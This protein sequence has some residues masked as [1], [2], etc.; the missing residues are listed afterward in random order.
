MKLDAFRAHGVEFIDPDAP[1]LNADCPFCGKRRKF[2]VN[3]GNL[4]WDCKVCGR[5]GNVQGFLEQIHERDQRAITPAQIAEIV[6]DRRLPQSALQSWHPGYGPMSFIDRKTGEVYKTEDCWQFA[7]RDRDG[8]LVDLR[9]YRPEWGRFMSTKSCNTGLFGAQDLENCPGA[10]VWL[11]EGEWDAIALRWLLRRC[12]DDGI[13]VSVPGAST[14]KADWCPW[15]GGR[16]VRTL[17]DN[18][19]AGDTGEL[20]AQKRLEG[21]AKKV[22]YVRWP[23]KAPKGFDVR[24]FIVKMALEREQPRKCLATLKQMFYDGPRQ[25]GGP[26]Q[27]SAART[28][29]V[30]REVRREAISLE[31]LHEVYRKWLFLDNT[32]GV[33]VTMAVMVSNRIEGDPLWMFIVGPPS[34]AKT[35]LLMPLRG[36]HDAHFTDSLTAHTLCSGF[37]PKSGDPSL[38]PR[39]NGKVLVVKDFTTILSMRDVVQD[40][41][42]GDLRAAYDGHFRKP[43]GNGIIREYESRFSLIGAVTPMIYNRAKQHQALGERF[44]KFAICENLDHAHEDDIIAKSISNMNQETRMRDELRDAVVS[45]LGNEHLNDVAELPK[46][47]TRRIVS[48]ARFGARM[49]GTVMRDPYRPDIVE[50]RPSSEVGARLGKQLA[51][52]AVSLAMVRHRKKVTDDDY[53]LVKKTVLD[54]VPQRYEDV[55]KVLVL[56]MRGE[57]GGLN[58][59]QVAARTRYPRSTAKRMLE[60]LEAL[61]IVDCM[62]SSEG[63]MYSLSNYMVELVEKADLYTTE[64]E[65]VDPEDQ[66]EMF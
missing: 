54:T 24:D 12:F 28:T 64:V 29:K 38:I 16:T 47:M 51:K 65:L 19:S 63:H 50:G 17:Y 57:G 48:L 53:A 9:G 32:D 41:I 45:Y 55:V 10:D 25:G 56:R 46:G 59:H 43:F 31:R 34:G 21:R 15:F 26:V 4:L 8:T 11:C 42:F 6:T 5:S 66:E 3:P 27:R 58:A 7:V 23:L 60:D 2:Y 35:E 18:D 52:L 22:F 20:L 33:D 61:E 39:L 36:R 30:Q 13:V 37:T 14:F 1:Q 49:R 62:R 44:L 40:E